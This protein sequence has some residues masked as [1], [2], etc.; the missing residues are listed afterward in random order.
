[1]GQ[2][3]F[4]K[5]QTNASSYTINIYRLGYYRATARAWWPWFYLRCRCPS[6]A[7]LFDKR[8]N[9]VNRL[10]QLGRIGVMGGAQYAPQEFILPT[11]AAGY[12]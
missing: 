12:R 1:V 2:T 10:R 3:I 8:L 4:F 9:W 7:G 11:C 5:I 6:S